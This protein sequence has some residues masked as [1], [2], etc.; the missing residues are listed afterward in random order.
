MTL[1]GALRE[2]R[3]RLRLAP[4]GEPR[5]DAPFGRGP[6]AARVL[7]R[8]IEAAAFAGSRLPA[9]LTHTLAAVGGTAE[10]AARPGLR[11]V[12]AENLSHAVGCPPDDPRVRRLV[13]EEIRNEARRSADLLWALGRREELRQTM[14]VEGVDHILNALRR[15]NGMIL[16][17]IH[18]GGWELA[19]AIPKVKIP[20][21]TTAI[22][23]DDWLA[24]GIDRLRNEAGLNTF[25][26][27]ES[28]LGAARILHRGEVLLLLGDDGWGESLRTYRVR[29]LDAWAHL[30]AGIVSLARLA[31]SPI[32]NFTCLPLRRRR[33]HILLDPALEPPDRRGGDEAEQATLQQLADRWSELIQ[34]NPAHWA[35]RYHVRWER[36]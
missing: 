16:C 32:V 2:R 3:R 28:A 19:T 31:Q 26:R 12:L 23:A 1:A 36:P 35:A 10:W 15:G 11:R 9:G 29:F 7:G 22:V 21:P 8:V 25:Y 24:W 14:V 5:P 27:T 20:V 30:P 34:E 6:A 33:W 4:D 17:G 13:L 18:V